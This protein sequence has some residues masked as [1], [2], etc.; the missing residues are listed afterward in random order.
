M[1]TAKPWKFEEVTRAVT[2]LRFQGLLYM[3]VA[4]EDDEQMGIFS[5]RGK[6]FDDGGEL[7][8]LFMASI[9]AGI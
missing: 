5:G 1:M 2:W 3:A 6:E 8:G 4:E 7:E 9:Q